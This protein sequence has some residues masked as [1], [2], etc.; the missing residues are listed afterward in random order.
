[1]KK[2]FVLFVVAVVAISSKRIADSKQSEI[3]ETR[4][5]FEFSTWSDTVMAGPGVEVDLI[6][7]IDEYEDIM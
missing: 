1:M 2:L 3:E 7:G 4:T 6:Y 5:P